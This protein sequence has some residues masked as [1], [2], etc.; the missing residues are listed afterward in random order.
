MLFQNILEGIVIFFEENIVPFIIAIIVIFISYLIFLFLKKEINHLA[1]KTKIDENTAK[2]FTNMSKILLISIDLTIISLQFIETL[3]MFMGAF[4][5]MGGTIIGFAAINTLGNLIAGLIIMSGKPFKVG[6]RIKFKNRLADVVNIKLIYTILE[7]IDGVSISVPNQKMLKEEIE[8]YGTDK[9]LRRKIYGTAGYDTDVELV[10]K[11]FLEAA[12]ESNNVLQFPE[13]HVELYDFLDYAIQY[14]L[15]VYINNSK[16]IPKFDFD[17]RRAV[18]K[19]CKK[20]GI[21]LS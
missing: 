4:T 1:R 14:R 18:L 19:N 6:D 15:I 5:A 11:A 20:Y 17:L 7:D 10:E 2:N 21:D 9:V 8:N 3:G 12:K 13:P 16:I